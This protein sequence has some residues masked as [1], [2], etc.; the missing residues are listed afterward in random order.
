MS[1]NS[2]TAGKTVPQLHRADAAKVRQVAREARSVA[3]QLALLDQRPGQSVRE[4]QRLNGE[5]A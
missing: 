3:E 4:R 5:S 2:N 1:M